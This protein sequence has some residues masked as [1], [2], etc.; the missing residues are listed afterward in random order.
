MI[1][2]DTNVAIALLN[3]RPPQVRARFDAALAAGTP[4]GLSVVVFHELMYGAA[5]SERRKANEDKIAI[6]VAAGRLS[7]LPFTPGDASEAADIRAHLKR[8]GSPIGPYDLL[9]AAQARRA[10][11][12][13]V[14]ANTREFA[15]VPGLIVA[16]WAA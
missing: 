4:L 5:A 1:H 10:G 3:D 12:T 15:R 2:L 11:T 16:D 9:I 14:T 6:F 7:L 8:T 13:L